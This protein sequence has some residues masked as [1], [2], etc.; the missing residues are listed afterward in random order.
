MVVNEIQE[1]NKRAILKNCDA[2]AAHLSWRFREL[3]VQI[4]PFPDN[5]EVLTK[6]VEFSLTFCHTFIST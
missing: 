4:L 5:D 6:K 2:L 3:L 1:Q